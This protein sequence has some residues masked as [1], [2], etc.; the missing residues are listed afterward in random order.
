MPTRV[1]NFILYI[2]DTFSRRVN[3]VPGP[4]SDLDGYTGEL[5][6]FNDDG[7]EL[8][9]LTTANGKMTVNNGYIEL[10]FADNETAA[11]DT[12]GLARSGTLYEPA[13][14]D[15]MPY[16]GTGLLARYYLRVTSPEPATVTTRLLDGQFVIVG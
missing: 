8:F 5:V 10:D 6:A 3:L 12:S 15:E 2:G 7:T 4:D 1:R 14:N 16:S 13:N 9:S 11:V